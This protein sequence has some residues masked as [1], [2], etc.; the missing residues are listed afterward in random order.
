VDRLVIGG[1]IVL[2]L[3]TFMTP[4]QPTAAANASAVEGALSGADTAELTSLAT[5]AG[6]AYASR[7][8]SALQRVTADDYVQIDVRGGVLNRTQWLDFVKNRRSELTVESDDIHVRYYGQVAVVTGEWT[9]I[10]KDNG[11]NT[12]SHSRW[13]SLWTR[14][15][16]GRKRHVFQNTYVNADA[17]HCEAAITH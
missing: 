6:R 5:K 12:M 16:D 3:L 15:P 17:D 7:D 11:N 2:G 4:F 1:L 13:T 9:Y 10:K 8:L 14:Y